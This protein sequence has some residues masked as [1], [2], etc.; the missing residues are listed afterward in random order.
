M[1]TAMSAGIIIRPDL[2]IS[3]ARESSECCEWFI[4]FQY[5]V[6]D[7]KE[8]LSLGSLHLLNKQALR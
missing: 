5:F 2:I 7:A 3:K 6:N 8:T 4:E 1:E